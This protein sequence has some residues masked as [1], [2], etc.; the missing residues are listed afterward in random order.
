MTDTDP[1]SLVGYED[2]DEDEH[3]EEEVPPSEVAK[4]ANL[5]IEAQPT[6]RLTTNL[7]S[8]SLSALNAVET[9]SVDQISDDEADHPS[10]RTS[11]AEP[12]KAAPAATKTRKR[13]KMEGI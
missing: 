5:S 7:S 9:S 11:P 3:E 12:Q 2:E 8:V 1:P 6:S 10:R 4:G 13:P